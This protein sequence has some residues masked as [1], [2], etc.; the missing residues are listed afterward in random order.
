MLNQ[1]NNSPK[2]DCTNNY[3]NF[4][5]FEL[6]LS[7]MRIVPKSWFGGKKKKAKLTKYQKSARLSQKK[8][9]ER[10]AEMFE[11]IQLP[12]GDFKRIKKAS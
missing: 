3:K 2:A 7:K 6:K 1:E 4:T 5:I 9:F 8:R 10:E 12:N 11:M